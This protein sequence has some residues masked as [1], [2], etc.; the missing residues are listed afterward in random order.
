[1]TLPLRKPHFI[2]GGVLVGLAIILAIELYLHTDRFL[3]QY[4]SVFAVGRAMDKLRYVEQ[5]TP[6]LLIIGNSRVDS[7]FDPQTLSSVGNPSWGTAF[8]L[9]IPGANA[10][11]HY[12]ILSRLE[13]EGQLGGHGIH[14]VV[15]GLD[16]SLVQSDDSLGYGVFSADRAAMWRRHQYLDYLR[17]SL[18]LWGYGDNLKELR[19]PE[20]AVRFASATWRSIEPVGG[21]AAERNGYRPGFSGKFQDQSQI[22]RQEVGSRQPPDTHVMQYFRDSIELLRRNRVEVVIVFPPLLTRNV[23][24][25]EPDESWA[26]PYIEISQ[27]LQRM[28]IPQI[29][30]DPNRQKSST[31]FVNA[32]HL[33]DSGAQL[34]TRLLA[35]ELKRVWPEPD[36]Q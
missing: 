30:L 32:G 27:K 33:N 1:M 18:R 22:M 10:R 28:G 31:E 6:S 34:Y 13:R 9:G 11:I 17:A 15:I 5:T 29:S 24:Y 2:G 14:K 23:A 8:N 25:L 35:L 3:Y 20:K 36:R 19:E 21:G 26:A 12:G 16:E 4:R 7:G